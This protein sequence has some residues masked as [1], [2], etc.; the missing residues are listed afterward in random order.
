M[1]S[2]NFTPTA[3]TPSSAGL[4]GASGCGAIS[5]TNRRLARIARRRAATHQMMNTRNKRPMMTSRT[6]SE[7][8]GALS[9]TL[10]IGP[11]IQTMRDSKMS[12]MKVHSQR[13]VRKAQRNRKIAISEPLLNKNFDAAVGGP[14]LAAIVSGKRLCRRAPLRF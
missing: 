10:T 6:I 2:R 14:T 13:E 4:G 9:P 1:T 3:A 5:E 12:P 8:N 11:K 7:A